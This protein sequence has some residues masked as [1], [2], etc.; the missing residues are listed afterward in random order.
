MSRGRTHT[1]RNRRPTSFK[2]ASPCTCPL[3]SLKS[4]KWSRSHSIS[5]SG[6]PSRRAARIS[7]CKMRSNPRRLTRPVSASISTISLSRWLARCN[8]ADMETSLRRMSSSRRMARSLA[9]STMGLTG[10]TREASPPTSIPPPYYNPPPHMGFVVQAG[11]E[12]EGRPVARLALA[13]LLG[14]PVAVLAG[15]PDVQQHQIGAVG[16]EQV[17]RCD[18]LGRLKDV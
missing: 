5:V 1:S 14:H 2:Q 15:Q 12:D 3:A 10:L 18:A 16:F 13:H 8:S 17:Q 9:I 11:E 7:L 6:V 4:L